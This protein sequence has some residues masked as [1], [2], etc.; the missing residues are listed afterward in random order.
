LT[1]LRKLNITDIEDNKIDI[2]LGLTK[3]ESLII[4]DTLKHIDIL[5]KFPQLKKTNIYGSDI[6]D[7]T[8]LAVSRILTLEDLTIIS[9]ENMTD[10]G[11]KYLSRLPNLK[12]LRVYHSTFDVTPEI[13]L[14]LTKL[15]ELHL[16]NY[17]YI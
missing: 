17:I 8:L 11:I 9:E 3:L 13:I 4:N 6:T 2:L 16:K 12:I 7:E 1:N 5:Q 14:Q 10:L 15:Q